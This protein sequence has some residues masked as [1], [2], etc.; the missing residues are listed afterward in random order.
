MRNKGG[1]EGGGGR[2]GEE[3]ERCGVRGESGKL[4]GMWAKLDV[5]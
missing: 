3:G 2:K 5:V 1:G 4:L